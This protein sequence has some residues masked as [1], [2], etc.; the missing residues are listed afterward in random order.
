MC[1][2][3]TRLGRSLCVRTLK[4]SFAFFS[5]Q[6][7]F[8]HDSFSI[9]W[10]LKSKFQS[11]VHNPKIG[12]SLSERFSPFE[13]CH[14]VSICSPVSTCRAHITMVGRTVERSLV[15]GMAGENFWPVPIKHNGMKSHALAPTLAAH[16]EWT[17][18]SGGRMDR[19]PMFLVF[20]LCI[21]NAINFLPSYLLT[22][23]CRLNRR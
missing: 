11:S 2:Q 14:A 20:A 5:G 4:L 21:F 15:S 3:W 6:F 23:P 7:Q 10:Q 12:H 13:L 16:A 18:S 17:H 8:S 1:H 19:K 22:S 9:Q